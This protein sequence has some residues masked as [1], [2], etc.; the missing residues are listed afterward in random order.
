MPFNFAV[1]AGRFNADCMHSCL[2]LHNE[3]QLAR[4]YSSSHS[5]LDFTLN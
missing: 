2:V 1:F 3:L 5:E 4:Q